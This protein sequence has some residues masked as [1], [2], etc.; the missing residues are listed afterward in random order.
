MKNK[1]NIQAIEL[2][3]L[4]YGYGSVESAVILGEIFRKSN[5]PLGASKKLRN[6]TYWQQMPI[7]Q[8]R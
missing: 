1:D 6:G 5:P 2:A 4:S 7:I 8:K 3:K